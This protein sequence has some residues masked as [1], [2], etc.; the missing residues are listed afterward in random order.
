MKNYKYFEE[1]PQII[2]PSKLIQTQ[3]DMRKQNR[4]FLWPVY[5][6]S[7]KSRSNGRKVPKKLSVSSPKLEELQRAAKRLS[8]QPKIVSSAAYPSSHWQKT[9]L[10]ILPKK[11][12]KNIVLKNIGKE[13]INL[14]R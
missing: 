11:E 2:K 7:G 10:L 12:S 3:I 4:I 8:L 9:G 13:L 5:F 6:D 14:R 1:K